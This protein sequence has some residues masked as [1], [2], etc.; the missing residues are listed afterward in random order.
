MD[1]RDTL[2]RHWPEYLM[3]AAGLGLFMV[4]ASTFGVL[5][6]HPGSP[7]APLLGGELARRALMG[8]AM[9][10]TAVALIYSP[11]GRRSGAHFNPAVTLTF[12]RLGKVAPWDAA[13]YILAQFA[14][15]V[16]GM[17]LVAAMAAPVVGDPSV[18]YVVTVPGARGAATAF[19]AEVAIAFCTMTTVLAASNSGRWAPYTGL[20]A[21]ALVAAYITLEAPLSGMSLNP[22]R[23]FASAVPAGV[24]T[25]YWIYLGAPLLGMLLAAEVRIRWTRGPV[26]CAKLQHDHTHRCIFCGSPPRLRGRGRDGRSARRLESIEEKG[27]IMRIGRPVVMVLL[28]GIVLGAWVF[29]SRATTPPA[30]TALVHAVEGVA[31]SVGDMDRAVD[32]YT[33]VLLFEKVSDAAV[34]DEA[35]GRLHGVAGARA[36]IVRLRLGRESL[37]L[38]ESLAPRGR[39]VPADSRSHDR[40][41]QH[42]AIIVN[43]MDQAHAWLRRHQVT[44]VSPEP[45]RLPDWNVEAAGIRAFYFQDPDGHP[46]EILQFPPGKGHPRWQRPGETVFLGIDHTAIVVGDTDRS[47]A[48]YRD[49]LGLRVAGASE[50]WGPEQERLNAVPGARLRITTLRAE[51]G[52]AVELLEYLTPGDGR[53]LP[54][55]ARPSDLVAWQTRVTVADAAGA[56]ASLLGRFTLLSPDV[57]APGAL[58]FAHAFTARDPD[59]HLLL[60][61]TRP[62]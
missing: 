32:F 31:I 11:W 51:S 2:S 17:L 1:M 57:I 39:P 23:T 33:R 22:A 34:A 28:L 58:G 16:S 25:A 62:R 56:R 24:W 46:L 26:A 29:T 13:F 19:V 49:A 8:L 6:F 15:G 53:A 36:R 54:A 9:A 7:L 50:N 14:G 61:G 18:N 55:D 42:V 10:L 48:F 35:Y 38:V 30:P 41:F 21:G 47:L 52:P 59:G 45:Q 37:D 27:L 12:L 5:L 3:E 40:W 60:L 4:S 43:D 44:P 20:C